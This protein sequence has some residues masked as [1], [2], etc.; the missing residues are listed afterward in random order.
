MFNNRG[1]VSRR[2][3]IVLL[4]CVLLAGGAIRLS[5]LTKE[6]L[7]ADEAESSINAF[8]ILQR[9]YPTDSYLGLP[10]YENTLTQRWPE[11]SEYEFR[12]SSYS[13][14]GVAVYHGWL[15]LYLIAGSLAA[16]G[17]G[18]QEGPGA[19]P[20]ASRDRRTFAA[21]L[22]S[23][24]FGVA[25]LLALYAVG[26][27][28]YGRDAGWAAMVMAC[29]S[30]AA[31]VASRQARYYA[32]TV[33]LA[34]LC[35]LASWWLV[36]RARWREAVVGGVLFVLLFHTHVLTFTALSI[37]L[38]GACFANLKASLRQAPKLATFGAIVAAGTVPWLLW[39][40]MLENAAAVPKV[41]PLLELQ[42]VVSLPLSKWP[43]TL[44][45]LAGV[46]LIAMR[47]RLPKAFAARLERPL[48]AVQGPYW[49][50]FAWLTTI[51]V[52]FL[53]LTPAASFFQGRMFTI[54][55]APGSLLAAMLFAVVG[56][57][58]SPR[59][60][61][62]IAA[63]IALVFVLA[64][65]SR[66][67]APERDEGFTAVLDHIAE[68]GYGPETKLYA[69]PSH[70]LPLTFYSGLPFQSVAPVR[71]CFLDGFPGRV[72]IVDKL[73]VQVG[74]N[75][76]AAPAKV[77]AAAEAAGVEL[78]ASEAGR[79]SGDLASYDFRRAVQ[80]RVG[81]VWPPPADPPAFALGLL[82]RQREENR[83]DFEAARKFAASVPIT[84]GFQV[85]TANDIGCIFFY[86]FVD[87]HSRCGPNLN[88]A[89]R[90]K[91]A[92]ATVIGGGWVLYDSPAKERNCET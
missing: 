2:L 89:E 50:G 80:S 53:F 12:D 41:L 9:G 8:T 87:P 15:P 29:L 14:K 21:R 55:G 30:P 72:V 74:A 61:T 71:K 37:V 62:P 13:K 52:C 46:A 1:S 84:R 68:A 90:L 79:L 6:Y 32:A 49:F 44:L 88:Y 38:A 76:P 85:Q 86:R 45:V 78:S 42:D 57:A 20:A 75:D 70:H 58:L 7:W 92:R 67:P 24:I 5:N 39:T 36:R 31:I 18:P 25:L 4:A 17:I 91:N 82:E 64:A 69:M 23:V 83:R 22:P 28:F 33:F 59:H 16:F 77:L 66:P 73:T 48:E 10:I 54:L 27:V 35:G 51:F 40:G 63:A 47:R 65:G 3:E 60:S 56:R 43:Y 19:L 81:A 26:R 11:H 34:L